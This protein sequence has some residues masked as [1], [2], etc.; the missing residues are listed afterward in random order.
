MLLTSQESLLML[1]TTN[2]KKKNPI[3]TQ[4]KKKLKKK[5]QINHTQKTENPALEFLESVK[6]ISEKA[7]VVKTTFE[8]SMMI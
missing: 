4:E 7:A 8:P 2:K 3:S 5:S 6:R 1:V